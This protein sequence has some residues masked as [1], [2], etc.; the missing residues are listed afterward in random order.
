MLSLKPNQ[1]L[2]NAFKWQLL[3]QKYEKE[4][5]DHMTKELLLHL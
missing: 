3:D 5:V 1:K 2:A 4:F